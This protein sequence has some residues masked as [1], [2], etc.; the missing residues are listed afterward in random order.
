MES[1]FTGKEVVGNAHAKRNMDKK[2]PSKIT[3]FS[4]LNTDKCEHLKP[5]SVYSRM[6]TCD[7]KSS[8]HHERKFPDPF[9]NFKIEVVNNCVK[10]RKL[11][12]SSPEYSCE[13]PAKRSYSPNT[14][15]PD[16]GCFM[17]YC[18]P[19]ARQESVS[20]LAI[21]ES[22]L[23]DKTQSIRSET[24][25]TVSSRLNSEHVE[26]GSTT[27]PGGD[28]G[29]LPNTLKYEGI[30][31]NLG[32]AFD[33]D[34]DDIMCLSPVGT[35]SAGGFSDRSESGKNP[36]S[37]TFQ[38]EPLSIPS[39]A[40]GQ[41]LGRGDGDVM[42]G[43]EEL[44]KDVHL[45]VQDEEEDK[46]Y[47]SMSYLKDCKRVNPQ[48]S[49]ATSSPMLRIGEVKV[50]ED[51]CHPESSAESGCHTQAVLHGPH[52]SF[53]VSDLCPT[54]S[55]L[56]SEPVISPVEALEGDVEEAWTIGPPMFESSVC[57]NV[58]VK[59]DAGSEQSRQVS[60]EVQ[61]GVIE[62]LHKCQTTLSGEETTLDTSYETTLPLQVQVKSV[63]VAPNQLTSSSKPVASALPDQN[64]K[65]AKPSPNK[66]RV[67]QTAKCSARS[68]RPVIFKREADW[69]HEKSLYVSSVTRH[70]NERSS[71]APDVM[72]ELLKLMTDVADQ[73]PGAMG[74]QWQHPSD[75]TRRNYQ[76]RFGNMVPKMSLHEWQAKNCTAHKRFAKVPKI[77]ER[78]PFP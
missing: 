29:T 46:G 26:C 47:F 78:S 70:M 62:P 38:N 9:I 69:E 75:L 67:S 28:E 8:L 56:P 74:K 50:A 43:R 66:N 65:P 36:S 40:E 59:L 33:F 35:S 71:A 4:R 44:K 5:L 58:T 27:E 14:L 25:E 77:F 57:H 51:D 60:E 76:R 21:S 55:G 11:D 49:P 19:L 23:L 30:L 7:Q 52:V 18:S 53:T 12:D 41:E 31:L 63:V 10:K 1:D 6:I 20:P 15:S 39:V 22:A 13:T 37:N 32:P 17:E 2:A 61:G 64:T 54:V 24:K 16:L 42:E 45:N 48:L 68:L 3:V 72:T 34:V 73:T